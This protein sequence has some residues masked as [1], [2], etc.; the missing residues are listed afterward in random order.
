MF[1]HSLVH[2][3]EF[4]Q[5]LHPEV[6]P[7]ASQCALFLCQVGPSPGS[8]PS[9]VLRDQGS[10]RACRGGHVETMA[11]SLGILRLVPA[12]MECALGCSLLLREICLGRK[13]G[14]SLVSRE[15]RPPSVL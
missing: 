1:L 10:Q 4:V 3:H 12:P 14:C 2:P 9:P 15:R 11:A 7:S 13:Q 8:K 5:T 6:R